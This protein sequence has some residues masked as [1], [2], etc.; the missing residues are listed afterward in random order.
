MPNEAPVPEA[1]TGFNRAD[2]AAAIK[3]QIQEHARRWVTT[4]DQ[5]VYEVRHA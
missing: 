3:A 2:E 5:A 4:F 1:V